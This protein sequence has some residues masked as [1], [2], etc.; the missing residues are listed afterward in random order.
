MKKMLKVVAVML[1]LTIAFGC[2]IAFAENNEEGT[3]EEVVIETPAATEEPEVQQPEEEK[4]VAA[5]PTVEADDESV[6]FI[7][8]DE[9]AETDDGLVTIEDAPVPLAAP[10]QSTEEPTEVSSEVPA[11]DIGVEIAKI[12]DSE[13]ADRSIRIFAK[14][15]EDKALEVGDKIVL[16]AV[17]HGYEGL[18]YEI[19]WQVADSSNGEWKDIA[20]ENDTTYTIELDADNYSCFYRA[21]VI[22]T[23]LAD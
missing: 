7:E 9:A 11:D 21:T 5:E 14:W 16:T 15:N 23:G 18:E 2:M 13:Y 20:G 8:E 22:I 17:L 3:T 10:E 1:A 6:E 12:I 19:Q 4:V